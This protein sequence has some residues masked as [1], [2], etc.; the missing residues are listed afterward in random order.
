[1]ELEK[2]T[3]PLAELTVL[4]AE[5]NGFTHPETGEVLV[6]GFINEKI[7]LVSKYTLSNLSEFLTK[8]KKKLED[9]RND[10]INKHGEEKDGNISIE[11]FLDDE[12]TQIN[13][14]FIEFQNEYNELLSLDKEVSYS[15][16]PVS[17]LDKIDSEANYKLI[18][19]LVKKN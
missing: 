10:L 2:I 4:E 16:I 9:V 8:E 6:K 7:N 17:E 15:P 1:M 3:L 12:K 14:K 5:L 11:T 19:K 18:F 13:P